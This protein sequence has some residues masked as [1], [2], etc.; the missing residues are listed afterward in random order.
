MVLVGMAT[1]VREIIV[2][3]GRSKGKAMAFLGFS[4]TDGDCEVTVFS[5]VWGRVAAQRMPDNSEM[6]AKGKV[7]LIQVSYD[8]RGDGLIC[9]DIVRLS[10]TGHAG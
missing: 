1:K 5:D 8:K 6:I 2:K 3:K 7:Y 10:N 4:G 9:D